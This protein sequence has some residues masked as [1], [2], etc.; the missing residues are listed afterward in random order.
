MDEKLKGHEASLDEWR[1]LYSLAKKFKETECWEWMYDTDIFGIEFD[2]GEVYYCCIMG[3]AKEVYGVNI[4]KGD[5]GLKSYF[6]TLYQT[7]PYEDIAFIQDCLTLHFE[8]R[9]FLDKEDL[10]VIKSLEIKFRGK[11][12]WP[13]FRNYKPGYYPASIEG[14]EVRALCTVLEE[15]INVCNRCKEDRSIIERENEDEILVR[16]KKEQGDNIG[17]IDSYI[18]TDIEE[19]EVEYGDI[20]ELALQ[21]LKGKKNR[22]MG[23]WEVDFFHAPALVKEGPRPFYPLVFIIAEC[24]T[25]TMLDMVMTSN[26]DGYVKEFQSAFMSILS[27]NRVLPETI[28]IQ[29]AD[30]IEVLEPVTKRLGIVL[31]SAEELL[32]VKEF[33]KSL[34]RF[35]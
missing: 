3:N 29:R 6:S 35:L 7:V 4:Y 2:A 15:A 20:D 28:I 21:R 1:S 14:N 17:W 34:E 24:S 12:S 8:D 26:F 31:Q 13:Q 10:D 22:K 18:T 32:F 11:K 19:V 27:K 23:T 9:D 5:S 33:R 25:G 30:A 16:I